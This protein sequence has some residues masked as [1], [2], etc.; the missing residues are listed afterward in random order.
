M[1]RLCALYHVTR[2]GYYGWRHRGTSARKRHEL[3]Q[4]LRSYMPYCNGVRLHSGIGYASPYR[5]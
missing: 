4:H 1:S 3:A 2:A 5:V